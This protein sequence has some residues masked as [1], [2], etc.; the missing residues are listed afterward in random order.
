MRALFFVYLLSIPMRFLSGSLL[1]HRLFMQLK[2]FKN[3]TIALAGIA[4]AIALVDQLATTGTA[5]PEA[6]QDRKSVV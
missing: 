6:L 2:T 3:Q 1:Y 5:D 4:Q